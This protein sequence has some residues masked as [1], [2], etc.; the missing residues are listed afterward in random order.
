M[1]AY[2][3][4]CNLDLV[5]T[6]EYYHS[7][8]IVRQLFFS[9]QFRLDPSNPSEMERC[10]RIRSNRLNSKPNLAA[11]VLFSL[12]AGLFRVHGIAQGNRPSSMRS[13]T[14][15]LDST[16]HTSVSYLL[17]SNRDHTVHSTNLLDDDWTFPSAVLLAQKNLGDNLPEEIMQI[18]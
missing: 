5:L 17:Q 4:G 2:Q 14:G 15:W 11:S 3:P 18:Y 13:N 9:L 12:P 8:K 16:T 7:N 10:M 1:T 6:E